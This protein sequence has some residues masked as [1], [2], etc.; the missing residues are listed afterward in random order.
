MFFIFFFFYL[1]ETK[2]LPLE[3][4]QDLF[5]DST[6]GTS[7]R[8]YTRMT[9]YSL[10]LRESSNE[11]PSHVY[12]LTDNADNDRSQS[13]RSS[14]F[15]SI[16]DRNRDPSNPYSTDK[17]DRKFQAKPY[18][19]DSNRHGSHNNHTINANY[20]E[21]PMS[22]PSISPSNSS[23]SN[24]W[25]FGRSMTG[26]SVGSGRDLEYQAHSNSL[27]KSEI[28]KIFRRGDK[29]RL[30][31]KDELFI[32][33]SIPVR[34]S[35]SSPVKLSS[36]LPTGIGQMNALQLNHKPPATD[37]DISRYIK[38]DDHQVKAPSVEI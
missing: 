21:N 30:N 18:P 12:L 10:Y 16:F 23:T 9:S 8:K 20:T 33:H 36:S 17:L 31:Q 22:S 27:N 6:W 34:S 35:F 13:Y 5:S 24:D 2:D 3:D 28:W 19:I 25:G 4:I 1:P 7:L 29:S 37:E 11:R 32:S 38:E 26:S 14:A 15:S